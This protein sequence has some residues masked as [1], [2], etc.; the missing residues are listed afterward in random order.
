MPRNDKAPEPRRIEVNS[1]DKRAGVVARALF[2]TTGLNQYTGRSAS[3][4][5]AI[6]GTVR[7]NYARESWIGTPGEKMGRAIDAFIAELEKK[8]E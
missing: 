1:K 2:A 7:V 6:K 4:L 5:A 8:D 3:E